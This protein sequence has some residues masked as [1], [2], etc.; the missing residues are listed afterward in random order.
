MVIF[1]LIN[2]MKIL[3]ILKTYPGES[4]KKIIEEHK[5]DNHVEILN[6]SDTK[7]YAKDYNYIV[8][9]IEKADRV[10]SW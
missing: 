2:I 9:L 10:I 4:A 1:Y 3:H 8:E 7:D 6:M 5:K